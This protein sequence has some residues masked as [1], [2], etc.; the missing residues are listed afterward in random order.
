MRQRIHVTLS[1][2]ALSVHVRQF[3]RD[4]VVARQGISATSGGYQV[5]YDVSSATIQSQEVV[6]QLRQ[7]VRT[8]PPTSAF[9]LVNASALAGRQLRRIFAGR[10]PVIF[11]SV[12]EA[13]AW[14]DS[15]MP[16][17]ITG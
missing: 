14:L 5:L 15:Q 6:A 12:D 8:S 13:T 4:L 3:E 17:P 7:L 9:A 1:G 2:F 10:E 16:E 11:D